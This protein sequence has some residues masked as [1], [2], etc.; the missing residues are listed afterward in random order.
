[1][2]LRGIVL[3]AALAA[4]TANVDLS[5]VNLALPLV[6]KAF[7]VGQSELAWT[8][9]AYVL[10]Y[11]VSILAWGR[12]GDRVGHRT[13]MIVGAGLFL[14]GS[15]ISAA[16]PTYPVLLVGRA[17]QGV[18]GGALL[19][20]GLAVISSQ[21]VGAER[22]RALGVYFAAG[23]MAAV[24]GP[25]V[26]G[27]LATVA[28]WQAIFWTQVPLA[29]LVVVLA[30]FLLPR[31]GSWTDRSFDLPG[32]ALASVFLFAINAALLQADS[33]GWTSL[34]IVGLW[35]LAGVALVAFV[36]RERTAAEPAVR[37][38]VFRSR[39]FV[40]SA[41]VGGAAWFGIL[42]GSV[43]LA[44]YLQT[45]R[46]LSPTEAA[47]VILPW[48]LVA[49]LLFPRSAAIVARLGPERVM[50][51]SLAIA[52][53]VAALMVGF[54]PTT[55]LVA[56]SIL[57]AAGGVPIALGV[58][59]STLKALAEFPPA[60]AGVASGVFNSLR[61]VGSSLGVAIP[62]ALF[63]A[64]AAGG[65]GEAALEAGSTAAFASRA[66]VFTICLV[67]V[68]MILPRAAR[69]TAPAAAPA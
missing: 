48:P 55:P 5:I 12:I 30:A 51:G 46:G 11:A 62:A 33:W 43:Q 28:G 53:V 39:V 58:T 67:L 15:L 8:V 59:A 68:V 65:T 7:G 29:A 21:F 60:E 38:S 40:A 9:N 13:A 47:L 24:I 35:L 27:W 69:R 50:I 6:G 63:D 56:V 25:L 45:I 32:L 20:I 14:V 42:S 66:V 10:P 4:F 16:S 52:A 19:T 18:G 57:A 31:P 49:G 54:G 1:V 23:A 17:V 22:G 34:G 36:A 26:G 61:Q 3:V 64:A 2:N 41:I 37:L 44:I